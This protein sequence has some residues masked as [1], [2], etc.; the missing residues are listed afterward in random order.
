M[1]KLVGS[2]IMSL[3]TGPVEWRAGLG[4][5]RHKQFL[6]R[7]RLQFQFRSEFVKT[8]RERARAPLRVHIR[9]YINSVALQVPS[10]RPIHIAE[11]VLH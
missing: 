11:D 7:Q 6:D 5:S 1:E 2:R 3:H 4:V 9:L 8:L 10:A